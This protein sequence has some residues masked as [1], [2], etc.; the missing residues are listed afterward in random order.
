M[1]GKLLELIIATTNRGKF[2]EIKA[3]L[4]GL[5]LTLSFLGELPGAPEVTED[6][7]TFEANARK[8]AVQIARWA[9]R[10][11]LA[12]DSGL[13]VPAL[14]GRPGVHSARYAGAGST[15]EENRKKLL[16]E[17]KDLPEARRSASFVCCLVVATPDGRELLVEDRCEGQIHHEPRGTGGFGYDPIFLI[18]SLGKTAAELPLAEKNKISHRGLA[19][20]RLR[21]ILPSFLQPTT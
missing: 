6:G 21:E 17:M 18:P 20:K 9:G 11:T 5:G 7:L 8:K 1:R 13:V 2:A 12:D 14:G 10:P 15:D 16:L 4:Q 3:A 19:L